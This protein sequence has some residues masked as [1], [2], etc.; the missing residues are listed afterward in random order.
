MIG[1][2]DCTAIGAVGYGAFF[3]IAADAA[4]ILFAGDSVGVGAV[5]GGAAVITADAANIIV[6][7]DRAALVQGQVFDYSVR[8]QV[9]HK[10]LIVGAAVIDRRQVA[11]G[12]A[13]TVKGA[14]VFEA[15]ARAVIADGRPGLSAQVDVVGQ[16]GP[17]GGV[18]CRAV[19]QSA[20]D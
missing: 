2:S 5:L 1:A 9:A 3:V 7:G 17:G 10:A 6:A 18:L 13:R 20:V 16:G 19:G 4:N 12:V 15:G 8:P 11:D 14:G